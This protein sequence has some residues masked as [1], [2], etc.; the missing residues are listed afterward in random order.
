M[1][2]LS[3]RSEHPGSGILSQAEPQRECFTADRHPHP[4]GGLRPGGYS[5]LRWRPG[6]CHLAYHR[7]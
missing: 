2:H 5:N 6:C 7:N 1:R 3:H 4:K